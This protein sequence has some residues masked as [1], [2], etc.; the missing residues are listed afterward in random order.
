MAIDR[1]WVGTDDDGS[2]ETGTVVNLAY[3]DALLDAIDVAEADTVAAI[4]AGDAATVAAVVDPRVC[5]GRLTLTTGVPVTTADV[6]AATT[7]YFTPYTGDR[8]SLYSGSAWVSRTFTEKT[9]ALGTL[10]TDLPYDVFAYDNAG[11]VA[12]ELLAWTSKT[13]RAT[14]IVRQDGVY[15]KTGAL[16]RRYLGTFHTT[17]TTTT[18]DSVAKR[19]LWNYANRVD[20]PLRVTQGGANS[21]TYTLATLR[22][23]RAAAG[24]QLAVVVGVAEVAIAVSVVGQFD[25]SGTGYAYVAIG[26]DSI[27]AAHAASVHALQT[28]PSAN[29]AMAVTAALRTLPAVGFHYYSWLE[30]AQATGT[31]TWYGL[32]GV[33]TLSGITGVI[34]G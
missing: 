18:E 13:A 30:Y 27:T 17:S 11:A 21:W 34:P 25:N 14:A 29:L 7:L 8:I 2:G 22:Q 20:R 23:A 24:N 10:T 26:E 4:T 28:C 5:D 19:L 3:M 9:L 15:C 12:L 31:T 1:S 6:T 33:G 16:T 32:Q